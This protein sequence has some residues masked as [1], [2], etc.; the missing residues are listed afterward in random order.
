MS[1]QTFLSIATIYSPCSR[2]I[3][4]HYWYKIHY[5]LFSVVFI[6]SFSNRFWLRGTTVIISWLAVC[7]CK[8]T[9]SCI[10]SRLIYCVIFIIYTSM[11]ITSNSFK[12]RI[13]NRL[14]LHFRLTLYLH[15][16]VMR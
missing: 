13:A 9:L 5:F 3:R 12:R 7:R 10:T 2:K 1:L 15:R 11:P 16:Q 4:L 14:A 6:E 8:N